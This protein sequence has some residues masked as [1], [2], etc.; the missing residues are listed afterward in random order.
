LLVSWSTPEAQAGDGQHA[1]WEDKAGQQQAVYANRMR[2]RGNYGKSLLR[3][4]GELVERSF[5][6]CYDTG[7]MQRTHLRK[8]DNILKRQLIHV[9]AFN[10]SLIFRR[11]LGAGTPQ[12]W[13]NLGKS[14]FLF[15]RALFTRQQGRI[16]LCRENTPAPHPILPAKSASPARIRT[17]PKPC[18]IQSAGAPASQHR[19]RAALRSGVRFATQPLANYRHRNHGLTKPIQQE[20][21]SLMQM[22]I[23]NAPTIFIQHSHSQGPLPTKRFPHQSTRFELCHQ[24][25]DLTPT[26]PHPYPSRFAHNSSP[27]RN[28]A[29]RQRALL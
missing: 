29:P 3:R 10:L 7:G 20:A 25:L 1:Y 19:I 15:L 26:T 18:P 4:S 2:V 22:S 14:L 21:E 27:S 28:P 6:H 23:M 16:R 17:S 12:E 11:L 24:R 9:G 5:A 8:H 13:Y